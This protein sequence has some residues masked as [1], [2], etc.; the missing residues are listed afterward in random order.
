[1]T[2]LVAGARLGPFELVERIGVGGMAEV[3]SATGRGPGAH[4]PRVALKIALPDR[5][6]RTVLES[7]FDDEIRL[8]V[9][10]RHEDILAVYGGHRL[11]SWLVQ[12]ME[13]VEGPDLRRLMAQV[14]RVGWRFP[15]GLLTWLL[16]R[17]ARALAYAHG[18]RDSAGRWL[19]ITHRDVSPHNI[20]VGSDGAVKVFDFGIAKAEGRKT[21]TRKGTIKGKASYMAPEQVRAEEV[22]QKVDV[23]A[24]GIVAWE[25]ICSRR[26]FRAPSDTDTMLRV[27][28]V[29]VPR[30]ETYRGDVP[31]PLANL[32]EEMLQRPP[33]ARPDMAQVEHRLRR[34]LALTFEPEE[35]G[36]EALSEWMKKLSSRSGVRAPTKTLPDGPR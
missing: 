14:A 23:F 16:W 10:L 17:V 26:L 32:V 13:L 28:D 24:L 2:V 6:D 35:V 22:T 33:E 29:E 11:D 12:E 1:M 30:V 19:E 8:S 21:F 7:T 20:L 3:W 5:A 25:L 4:G 27:L 18:Y 36:R 9:R 15:T 31:G 34:H